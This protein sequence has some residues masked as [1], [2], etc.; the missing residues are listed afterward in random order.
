MNSPIFITGIGTGIGKTVAAAII[1][2]ALEADYWK[3]VQAGNEDGTDSEWVR[4]NITNVHSIV[5]P[6]CYSLQ[7]AASPHFSA[8]KE[9]ITISIEHIRRQL[10]LYK[11]NL[12]IEGAGG[13]LVPLNEAEFIID[14]IKALDSA[15]L[16]VSRNYLGSINHSLLTAAECKRNNLSVL[17]WFFIG[18]EP[19][20]EK[21]ISNW[22]ELPVI[23]S[24]PHVNSPGKLFVKEMAASRSFS[25]N[26]FLC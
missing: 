20:Y 17:G 1:A 19:L 5:H 6:E 2:E 12:I 9:N 8:Q 13:L 22:T 16:L 7:L 25:L 21:Q 10:P 24:V 14:L 23:A 18:Y 26:H 3:P 15:V 11:K 4:N